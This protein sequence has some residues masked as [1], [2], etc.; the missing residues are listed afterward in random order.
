MNKIVIKLGTST[1]TQGTKQLSR[2]Y[3]LEIARQITHLLEQGTSPP[4]K[5]LPPL[6]KGV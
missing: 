6:G 4:S 3:M 2:R 1:L 5:C